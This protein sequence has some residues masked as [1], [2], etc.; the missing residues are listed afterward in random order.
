MTSPSRWPSAGSLA[1]ASCQLGSKSRPTDSMG[2]TPRRRMHVQQLA[3]ND[4]DAGG[5][6]RAAVALAGG[7]GERPFEVVDDRQQIAHQIRRDGI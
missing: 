3:V 5:E 4:L 1:I 2:S 7:R 6:R